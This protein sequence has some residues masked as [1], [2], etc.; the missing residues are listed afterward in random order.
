MILLINVYTCYQALGIPCF[1][2]GMA[3]GLLGRNSNLHIRQR[4]RDALKEADL[5][6]LAGMVS[7]NKEKI[8]W[9]QENCVCF[10]FMLILVLVQIT[11]YVGKG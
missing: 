10:C 6:I 3:R 7:S 9:L 5:V 8:Y 11:I 1:L 4:R 2:G